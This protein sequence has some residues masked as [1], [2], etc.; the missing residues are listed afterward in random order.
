V[1]PSRILDGG[2]WNYPE[3][4]MHKKPPYMYFLLGLGSETIRSVN[5]Y[6]TL[7][8]HF[9]DLKKPSLF[10]GYSKNCPVRFLEWYLRYPSN[11]IS[12]RFF[13]LRK[14]DVQRVFTPCSCLVNLLLVRVWLP[15]I[16]TQLSWGWG[17][18]QRYGLWWD[19]LAFPWA[20]VPQ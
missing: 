7:H 11:A 8:N 16:H 18:Y 14:Q 6:F 10:T 12:Q 15:G 4:R 5:Q 19:G 2:F 20:R 13:S 9:S 1:N 3:G 17:W